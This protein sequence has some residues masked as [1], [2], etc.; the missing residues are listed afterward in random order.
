[1]KEIIWIAVV[2]LISSATYY[3]CGD[4]SPFMKCQPGF[5]LEQTDFYEFV[6]LPNDPF[7]DEEP[8]QI[9]HE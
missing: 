3:K 4:G 2:I 8:G 1:M 7:W 6:C 9:P 5:D